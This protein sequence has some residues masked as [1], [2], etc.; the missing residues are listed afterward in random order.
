MSSS[1]KIGAVSG[2]IAGIAFLIVSEIFTGIRLS[3]DLVMDWSRPFLMGNT[4]VNIPLFLFWG[5][6]LGV[7]YSKAHSLIQGKGVLKGLVYGLF[8]FV[9][10]SVRLETFLIPYGY[11]ILNVVG[12]LLWGFFV[13]ISYGLVLGFLYEFLYNKYI[14]TKE[15]VKILTYDMKSGL[16]PGAIAGL[17]QGITAGVVSVIGHVTGLWGVPTSGEIVSTISFWVAQFGTHII[18]NM[19]WAIIFGAFFALVYN[20][21]PGKR[22]IKGIYYALIMY[23]ITMV[24][25][26]TWYTVWYANHNAWQLANSQFLNIFVFGID[27]VIYGLVLG[28]LYRKPGD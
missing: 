8:F 28:Y 6:V 1:W 19:L 17:M 27:D 23:F 15:E 7:I 4:L 22:V 26:F 16:L 14:P 12:N 5:M 18:I 24:I 25:I 10:V 13:W 9:F 20:L 11:P 21:V 3:L 2:L